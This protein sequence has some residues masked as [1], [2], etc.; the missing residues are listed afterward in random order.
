MCARYTMTKVAIDDLVAELGVSTAPA[1]LEGQFNIAPTED[2][3]IVIASK[4]G[5]RRL[6]LARFGFVPHWAKSLKEG[7]RYLNARSETV[8]EKPAYRDALARH[9][10]LVVADGFYEWRTEG[11]LKV[12][13]WF[14]LPDERLFAFAG[15][16]SAW[17]DPARGA[18]DPWVTSFTILTREA[19]GPVRAVHDRMPVILTPDTYAAWLDRDVR[20]VERVLPLLEHVRAGELCVREVSRRVNDVKS[21]G[22]ELLEP[23]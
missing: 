4:E 3:P 7:T 19:E 23:V 5:E 17:R 11:K 13:F 6:G 15:L 1:A 12:P 22:P 21:D 14:H 9:R 10:C 18:E 16:W 2:A 8:A 20:Q